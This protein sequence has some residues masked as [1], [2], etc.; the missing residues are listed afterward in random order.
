[1]ISART[2]RASSRIARTDESVCARVYIDV[3]LFRISFNNRCVL[4]FFGAQIEK[5]FLGKK[6]RNFCVCFSLLT[7]EEEQSDS[8]S[9]ARA[10]K[11]QR[12]TPK[13]KEE[14]EEKKN[15]GREKKIE[16]RHQSVAP[17]T[18][19][20]FVSFFGLL[21]KFRFRSSTRQQQR[22]VVVVLVV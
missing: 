12:E 6:K 11:R 13:K 3:S 10:R 22:V 16:R 8:L 19:L 14:E 7:E 15:C 5:T 9:L 20:R 18:I 21:L 1:M 4:V 2:S 17:N